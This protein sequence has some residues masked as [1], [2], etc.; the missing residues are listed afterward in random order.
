MALNLSIFEIYLRND[1]RVTSDVR[2][3][4]ALDLSMCR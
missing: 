1:R 2:I 4:P 3:S